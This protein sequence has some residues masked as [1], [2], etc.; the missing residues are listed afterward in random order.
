MN[1]TPLADAERI[2]TQH[3]PATFDS[4]TSFAFP[5]CIEFVRAVEDE[6][7]WKGAY[8]SLDDFYAA[9]HDRHPSIR[10]YA[11]LRRQIMTDDPRKSA[12]LTPTQ[13]LEELRGSTP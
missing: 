13:R 7:A 1:A 3:S 10:Y 11:A 8:S 5:E 6:E 2:L 12:G 9:H 4:P